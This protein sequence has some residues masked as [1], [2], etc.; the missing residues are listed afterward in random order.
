MQHRCLLPY[1]LQG[2]FE[3][4]AKLIVKRFR[5]QQE[6][7]SININL[8]TSTKKARGA[9]GGAQHATPLASRSLELPVLPC[10]APTE[11]L[12]WQVRG[13]D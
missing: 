4:E 5:G 12:V 10:T 7:C 3:E 13:I 6:R 8:F 2:A 11:L 9:A 1:P